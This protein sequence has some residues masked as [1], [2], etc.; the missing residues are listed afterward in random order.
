MIAEISTHAS[1][2]GRDVSF[3]THPKLFHAFQPTRPLRDAT[4]TACVNSCICHISTHA[5]LAGRDDFLAIQNRAEVLFQPT[6]PLRD[7][8]VTPQPAAVKIGL[9]QPTRPLRDATLRTLI[10]ACSQ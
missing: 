7:A 8:T 3:H 5:S 1:L 6:R 4:L 10:A 2:A 9:F